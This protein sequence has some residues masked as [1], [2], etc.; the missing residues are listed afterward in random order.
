MK[1]L[2]H[3]IKKIVRDAIQDVKDT[4][5]ALDVSTRFLTAIALTWLFC[6]LIALA[7]I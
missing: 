1:Q 6:I 7:F 5:F 4:W 3:W 2:T